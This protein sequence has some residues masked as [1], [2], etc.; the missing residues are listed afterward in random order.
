MAVY[1]YRCARHGRYDRVFPI[2]SAPPGIACPECG[3]S[4]PRVF[5]APM[6]NTLPRALVGARDRAEKSRSEPDVVSA[7]PPRRSTPAG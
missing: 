3:A 1:E 2:G 5:S 6:V 7:L 4:V